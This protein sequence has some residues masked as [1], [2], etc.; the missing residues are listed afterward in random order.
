VA[1]AITIDVNVEPG[2]H[3]FQR[4][5]TRFVSDL[6]DLTP[7]W[8]KLADALR[9]STRRNFAT[10]G[11]SSG[12][13]WHPLSPRYG[14]WKA[15]HYPGQPILQRSGVMM[16]SLVNDGHG[17]IYERRPAAMAWGTSVPYAKYHQTGTTRGLP[18]RPIIRLTDAD[19]DDMTKLV[20]RHLL[21]SARGLNPGARI[22]L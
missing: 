8:D 19:Q 21:E 17:S 22:D 9:D 12:A 6:S 4:A 15:K 1:R 14:T 13:R 18:A 2:G 7:L 16:E 20:H 11:A 3:V 10:E 5:F